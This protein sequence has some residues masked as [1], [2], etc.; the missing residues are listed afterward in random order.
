MMRLERF[1]WTTPLTADTGTLQR[2]VREVTRV[3]EGLTGPRGTLAG[4]LTDEAF[5][6]RRLV[7]HLDD[8]MPPLRISLPELFPGRPWRLDVL[9]ALEPDGTHRGGVFIT[10]KLHGARELELLSV[11]GL[12]P[13]LTTQL[14][15]LLW[16]Q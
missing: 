7:V 1:S 15:L 12:T 10:W 6:A 13:A 3:F 5:K 2:F 9:D 14:T 8:S 11:A 16:G 4:S